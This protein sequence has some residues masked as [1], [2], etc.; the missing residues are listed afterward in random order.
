M[1]FQVDPVAHKG[2]DCIMS[3]LIEVQESSTKHALQPCYS[4]QPRFY[5]LE[6]EALT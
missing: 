1:V 2:F 4:S 3:T 5:L 6:P